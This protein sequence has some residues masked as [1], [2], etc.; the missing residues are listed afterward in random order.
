MLLLWGCI[1]TGR[2]LSCFFA[3]V[4]GDNNKVDGMAGWHPMRHFALAERLFAT[5]ASTDESASDSAVASPV[6][7]IGLQKLDQILDIKDIIFGRD[8]R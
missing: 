8:P 7:M 3:I 4:L 5:E 6:A 2:V 1:V